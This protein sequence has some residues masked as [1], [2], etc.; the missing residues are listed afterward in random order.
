MY[1]MNHVDKEG[2]GMGGVSQEPILVHMVDP[3]RNLNFIVFYPMLVVSE[4]E[5][6][7]PIPICQFD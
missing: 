2:R 4:V 3:L 5:F 7:D 6:I 1:F